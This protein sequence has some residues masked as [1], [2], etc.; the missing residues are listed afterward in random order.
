MP[1]INNTTKDDYI[2]NLKS[3]AVYQGY[4]PE[5]IDRMLAN[6]FSPEEIEEYIYCIECEV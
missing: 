3:I 5:D 4:T 1:H 2:E 6:G